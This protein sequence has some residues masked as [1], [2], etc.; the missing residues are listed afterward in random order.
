MT[1]Q[2]YAHRGSS[3]RFAEHT[4]AAYRQALADGADGLEC[5]LHLTADGALVLI[6]DDDVDRT[7]DGSGP[8]A[9]HT[10]D[11][12]RELDFCSWKGVGIPP[13]FGGVPEQLLTLDELLDIGF[14]AGR[15]LGLAVE[16]KF[17]AAFN[18]SPVD[19]AL[20]RLRAR[21]WSPASSTAGN[22]TV[23]F[24]SFHPEAI[25]YLAGQLAP[26]HL[27]QLLEDV[28][29]QEVREEL[30]LGT[31][32]GHTVAFLLRRA[33]ADGEAMLDDGVANLAGLGVD[34]LR[35][36]P[37][38]AAR[39][40]AAGRKM[41]VWTVDTDADLALCRAAGVAEVTTN[42]PAEIRR[43]LSLR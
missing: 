26:E 3:E 1:V 2:I 42:R 22:L 9:E 32:A 35:A 6:H 12:L 11:Q 16:F 5:D 40:L 17:G 28:E 21:G 24:M 23:S 10:L 38:N 39:W 37:E 18:P 36:N 4:R 34:Y 43:I 13:E 27:C 19:A 20:D 8:V 25:G 41:R 14:D 29:V 30:D 33:M 31:V 15:P 7:S